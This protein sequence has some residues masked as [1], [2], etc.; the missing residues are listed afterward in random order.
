MASTQRNAYRLAHWPGV[1]IKVGKL[2]AVVSWDHE[3]QGEWLNRAAGDSRMVTP[4]DEL[5]LDG[6]LK[7]DIRDPERIATFLSLHGRL[8]TWDWLGAKTA[9]SAAYDTTDSLRATSGVSSKISSLGLRELRSGRGSARLSVLEATE[10]LK[11][12]RDASRYYLATRDKI[13]IEAAIAS[14]ESVLRPP[15]GDESIKYWGHWDGDLYEVPDL[16]ERRRVWAGR[17]LEDIVNF[18]LRDF[19]MVIHVSLIADDEPE[20]I[21]R[22]DTTLFGLLC[23]QIANHIARNTDLLQCENE[24]CGRWFSHQIGRGKYGQHRTTGVKYCSAT[25]ARTQGS[26]NWRKRQREKRGEV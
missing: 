23:L 14:S 10:Q 12:V 16:L 15:R 21:W 22:E 25:C 5:F 3:V 11:L 17:A 9:L 24:S 13:A 20:G 18:G 1:P 26:R 7:L 4:P 6:L 19:P 2:P 8:Q